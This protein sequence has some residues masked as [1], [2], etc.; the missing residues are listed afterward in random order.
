[1]EAEQLTV[2]IREFLAAGLPAD[3]DEVARLV[4]G[5]DADTV[6]RALIAVVPDAQ[7]RHRRAGLSRRVSDAT[8]ADIE[9]KHS[10]YGAHTVTGWLIGILRGDVVQVGRLQVEVRPG[11]H[12]HALHVPETGPLIDEEVTD[13]LR[14]ARTLTGSECFSCTSWLLDPGLATV[15]P[16]SN[17]AAFAERFEVVDPGDAEGGDET[18]AKFVFRLPPEVVVSGEVVPRTSLERYVVERLREGPRWTEP[19]GVLDLTGA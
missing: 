18:A 15:L 8:L 5:F 7:D 13:S 12:G 16:S 19:V 17:I 14:Q 1:M 6:M 3:D 9:R 10:L 2:R 11:K 4:D